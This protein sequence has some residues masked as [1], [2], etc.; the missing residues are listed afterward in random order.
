LHD[1]GGT[2]EKKT[3][4]HFVKSVQRMLLER[5][6]PKLAKLLGTMRD[7]ID[8]GCVYVMVGIV[9]CGNGDGESRMRDEVGGRKK[10]LTRGSGAP[11]LRTN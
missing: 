9:D 2:S 5:A 11:P 10:K 6:R 3:S 1:T 7:M 4:K 8:S